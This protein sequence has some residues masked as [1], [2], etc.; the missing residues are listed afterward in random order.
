MNRTIAAAALTAFF[1]QALA[2]S[3]AHAQV[4]FEQT[5]TDLKSPDADARFR[6]ASLLKDAAYP[7]AALPLAASVNDPDPD[8]QIQA[9]G[10]ELNIYLAEKVTSSRRVGFL[11]ERRQKI[12]ADASFSA[13]RRAVGTR[14]VPREVATALCRATHATEADVALEALYAFGTL[15]PEVAAADRGAVLA[16]AAPE[17]A[18]LLGSPVPGMRSAV[19]RVVARVYERRQADAVP[20]ETMGD[21]IISALNDKN[22]DMRLAAMDA[23]GAMRYDR[24]VQ[25]LSDL[26]QYY[27]RGNMAE[28]ALDTLA[29]IGSPASTSLFAAQLSTNSAHVKT[30]AIEGLARV[31]DPSQ[32]AAIEAAV[33]NQRDDAMQLAASFASATLS[34]APITPLIDALSRPRLHDQAVAYLS[35]V[36]AGRSR[37][38]MTGSH[39]PDPRIRADVADILGVAGDIEALPI[40]EAMARD[41][42]PGAARSAERASARLRAGR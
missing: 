30:I 38:L 41:E 36:A 17:L 10:A 42:D 40:V 7:E 37:Q 22:P 33:A 34:N 23:L 18:S 24:A 29:R 14:I 27:R 5:L 1:V 19:L 6:A 20:D 25:A 8:V 32:A 11:I 13:G 15:A 12:S 35:E 31:G 26:F 21:A 16:A 28:A 2:P 3:V 4:T 39:D 9:I